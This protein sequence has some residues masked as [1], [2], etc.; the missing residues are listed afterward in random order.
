M[1]WKNG[2]GETLQVAIYPENVDF[3][4]DDFVWRLSVSKIHDH[5]SFSTFPGYDIAIVPLPDE[6]QVVL[7]L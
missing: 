1:T 4:A 5:C 7:F 6:N 3:H 2:L